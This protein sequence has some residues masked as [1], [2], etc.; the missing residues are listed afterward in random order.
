MVCEWDSCLGGEGSGY[1]RLVFDVR[2]GAHVELDV[3]LSYPWASEQ[4]G[5]VAV[6][7]SRGEENNK[8]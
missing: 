7:R 4:D 3:A 1:V 8:M 5:A 2:S 6:R